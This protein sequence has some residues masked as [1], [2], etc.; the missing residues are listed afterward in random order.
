MSATPNRSQLSDLMRRAH[1]LRV[2]NRKTAGERFE[3]AAF[4][5]WL[6][7]AWDEFRRGVLPS[8]SPEAVKARQIQSLKGAITCEMNRGSGWSMQRI[9]ALEA[10]L[11]ALTA[12]APAA[13]S[14]PA[15]F[16]KA[17]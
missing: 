14:A 17:A 13:A 6:K 5:F 10:E 3:V 4:G 15:T 8:F 9:N 11:A 16:H 2:W 7:L 1:Q 12:P